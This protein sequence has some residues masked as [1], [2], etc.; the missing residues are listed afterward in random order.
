MA[1]R[2]KV[3][4][5]WAVSTEEAAFRHDCEFECGRYCTVVDFGTYPIFRALFDEINDE[6]PN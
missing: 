2:I 6:R 4:I 3:E 1:D 5:L